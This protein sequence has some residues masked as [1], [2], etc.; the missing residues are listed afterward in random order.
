MTRPTTTRLPAAVALAMLMLPLPACEHRFVVEEE[1]SCTRVSEYYGQSVDIL[2]VI[3]SSGS[4]KEEQINLVNNFPRLIE[5]LRSPRL[6]PDGSGKP[7]TMKDRRG[8]KLPN[9]HV[10][11]VS[12]DLSIGNNSIKNCKAF[13]PDE[14]RLLNKPRVAGCTPP[15]DAWISYDDGKTN[16]PGKGDPIEK[17]KDAFSC[18]ARLGTNGCGSEQPL[19]VAHKALDPSQQVNPGFLR[20]DPNKDDAL[21]VVVFITDEDDCSASN[22]EIFKVGFDPN[23]PIC[24]GCFFRC[25][26]HGVECDVNGHGSGP[27]KDCKPE[28]TGK[29]LHKIDRY[30]EFFN[31]L[32]KTPEGNPD[33][34]RVIMAAIAGPTSP[35][36][37]APF[38]GNANLQ[39]SCTTALGE[40]RPAIRLE[41]LVHAFAPEVLPSEIAAGVPYFVDPN[42]V[43]REQNLT[44]ICEPSFSKP[45]ERLGQSIV[46]TLRA[47]C[48]KQ[49]SLTAG[50]NVVCFQGD[51]MGKDLH[52]KQITCQKSCLH[53]ANLMVEQSATS[54]LI[55][56]PRCAPA[57]FDPTLRHD[58]CSGTC[59]CWRIVPHDSCKKKSGFS[60]YAVEIMRKGAPARG[61]YLKIC[62]LKSMYGWGSP[63]LARLPQCE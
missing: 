31:K 55:A 5:A 26:K 36:V 22:K 18:I 15:S 46:A 35:V 23:S 6:G 59:P 43:K 48:L 16:I 44:S 30:L 63:L 54:K 52:G 28:S 34:S 39:P 29:Y 57:L 10:G 33:P 37:V 56:V 50:G 38:N 20:N 11:V 58:Q 41:A 14:A 47:M 4:M 7:C 24:L 32:K 21:L 1:T 25:F 17:V 2:F 42:G 61:S 62:S 40:A 12:T 45:L 60:P 49:P 19:E 9:L 53:Q 13:M 8:C 3:D 27:R 51:D